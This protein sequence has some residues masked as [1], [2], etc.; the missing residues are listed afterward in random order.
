MKTL[1]FG[2]K[3]FRV[4]EKV[5]GRAYQ[6]LER[7]AV[8]AQAFEDGLTVDNIDSYH[9]FQRELM[10]TMVLEADNVDD[11]DSDDYTV[12]FATCLESYMAIMQRNA[13]KLEESDFLAT[14]K[15]SD[16]LP[17]ES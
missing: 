3:V 11:M 9:K 7:L 13:T 6:K 1:T 17:S 8:V 10:I 2:E 16:D 5:T 14:A 4:L 15:K 12:L